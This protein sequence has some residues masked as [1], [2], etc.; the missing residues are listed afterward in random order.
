MR[1]GNRPATR[2]GQVPNVTTDAPDAGEG[3]PRLASLTITPGRPLKARII[4][5]ATN[6]HPSASSFSPPLAEGPSTVSQYC[7][8]EDC[9]N[10]MRGSSPWEQGI[11]G[12]EWNGMEW[13]GR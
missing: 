2:Q 10:T 8:G 12:M 4:V 5:L 9:L 6:C 1:R 3:L 7:L 13:N 11:E